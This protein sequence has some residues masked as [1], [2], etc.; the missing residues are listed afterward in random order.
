VN[1][2]RKDLKE[3]V[4]KGQRPLKTQQKSIGLPGDQLVSDERKEKK[5]LQIGRKML[6]EMS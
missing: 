3:S 4:W 5:I 2:S 6:K 1:G